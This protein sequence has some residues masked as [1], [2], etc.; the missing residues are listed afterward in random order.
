MG[1][2]TTPKQS[3]RAATGD[4]DLRQQADAALQAGQFAE[5]ARLLG[6]I[7]ERDPATFVL[8]NLARN[9][10][11]LA[12]HRADLVDAIAT[13]PDSDRYEL[14]PAPAGGLTVYRT[15]GPT[16]Q[17]IA[18]PIYEPTV[19][20]AT[21]KDLPLTLAGLGNGQLLAHLAA[22]PPTLL[23]TQQ[24]LVYVIEPDVSLARLVMMACDLT[25]P[26]GQPRFRW[27]VGP[28][29][30]EALAELLENE[31]HLQTP[32]HVV[33]GEPAKQVLMDELIVPAV[34]ARHE[35]DGEYLRRVTEW[36]AAHEAGGL[37]E[38]LG[39][40]A[41]R[42]PRVLLL[43]SR[44]T[45]VLQHACRDA[46]AAFGE[47]GWRAQLFIEPSDHHRPTPS[48]LV[49]CFAEFRPDL[50]FQIDHQRHEFGNFMP[51]RVPFVCWVQDLMPG[52]FNDAA[53]AKVGPLDF[54]LTDLTARLH[55]EHGYPAA[56]LVYLNK[57]TRPV[58]ARENVEQ[59][60]D[61]LFVSHGGAPVADM[62]DE[63]FGDQP[64]VVAVLKQ[65]AAQFEQLVERDGFDLNQLDIE[66]E[67][68]RAANAAGSDPAFIENNREMLAGKLFHP[69]FDRVYRHQAVGWAADLAE[70]DGLTLALYGQ[71]WQ[72]HP[73]FA[74][75][76]RGVAQYGDELEQ[77]T[78][79]SR[80]G[81]QVVPFGCLHQRLLDG[82]SAGGFF[83]VR[84]HPFDTNFAR[85]QRL[86]DA[87]CDGVPT[88][89]EEA[90]QLIDT[91]QRDELQALFDEGFGHGYP[92]DEMVWNVCVG[93]HPGYE[94]P[95]FDQ[96][97][98]GD[99][100]EFGRRVRHYLA[101]EDERRRIAK[102]QAAY[103]REHF[104]YVSQMKRVVDT[105]AQKLAGGAA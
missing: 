52:I 81:L 14:G 5:A 66:A 83:V 50:I 25:E 63:Q 67:L 98:F 17:P 12:E 1:P 64:Q 49:R 84:R 45:T 85:L 59:D 79:R 73:R 70:R 15:D 88:S 36:D 46:A 101:N 48:A 96:I 38:L 42:Q 9:L 78:R 19:A 10:A 93:G 40:D 87:Y 62:I 28:G 21:G 72:S 47:L 3:L 86:L 102:R 75:Y 99:A 95:G 43:T 16:P 29:A 56:Q 77:L 39:D 35:R 69:V 18:T 51:K 57:A 13:A 74:A 26:I 55:R 8:A 71:G 90:L 2:T 60:I 58:A 94:L 27:C 34:Q 32:E 103:V 104:G 100:D 41:P 91:E 23:L 31:P 68:D 80:I 76:A 30:G 44:F 6:R 20:E 61:L 7:V 4:A 11:A 53:A 22:N 65:A 37:I 97:T 89:A 82:L 54:L 105:V 33:F 92:A 24:Q